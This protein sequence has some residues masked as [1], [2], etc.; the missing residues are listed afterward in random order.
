MIFADASIPNRIVITV[1]YRFGLTRV[2]KCFT[3][4]VLEWARC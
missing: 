1:S 3:H 4:T 2:L